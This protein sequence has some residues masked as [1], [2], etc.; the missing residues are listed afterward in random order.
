MTARRGKEIKL[1]M[2]REQEKGGRSI[3]QGSQALPDGILG[4]FGDAVY[5]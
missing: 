3:A 2:L 4:Q 5:L 1:Q